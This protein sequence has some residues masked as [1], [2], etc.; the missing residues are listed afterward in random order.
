ML[1]ALLIIAFLVSSVG[2]AN[3]PSDAVLH[4]TYSQI[5]EKAEQTKQKF[6]DGFGKRQLEDLWLFTDR[7]PVAIEAR[8]PEYDPTKQIGY[9]F[10]RAMTAHLLARRLGLAEQAG[11]KLFAIG[12]MG[13]WRFHVT[14]LARSRASSTEQDRLI[15]ID[16]IMQGGRPY[17]VKE[18]IAEVKKYYVVP[19]GQIYFYIV[20]AS[21]VVPD[22]RI[23]PRPEAETGERV[24]EIK[25]DPS[26]REGDGFKQAPEYDSNLYIIENEQDAG[27]FFT[28]VFAPNPVNAFNFLGV[29]INDKQYLFGGSGSTPAHPTKWYFDDLLADLNRDDE[30]G[31]FVPHVVPEGRAFAT[32]TQAIKKYKEANKLG[33]PK[34]F[35]KK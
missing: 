34:F 6:P 26:K 27:R 19:G 16:P 23:V 24:I 2:T 12:E 35:G 1:R 10:G 11:R 8:L 29:L 18:W 14:Y 17:T 31:R 33:S 7:H 13:E 25:F 20:P 9:C 30:D 21:I 22:L 15:A 3:I 28:G 5:L 4:D 32:N